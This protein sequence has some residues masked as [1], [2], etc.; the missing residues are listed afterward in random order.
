MLTC[1][2]LLLFKRLVKIVGGKEGKTLSP[3]WWGHKYGFVPGGLLGAKS[4]GKK[5]L[6]TEN[7]QNCNERTAF[8]EQDQEDLYNLVQVCILACSSA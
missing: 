4:K 1:N 7:P 8:H 5:Y 6:A 3:D 2:T